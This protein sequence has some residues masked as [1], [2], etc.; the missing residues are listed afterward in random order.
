MTIREG[1]LA[2]VALI[3]SVDILR[4]KIEKTL[5]QFGIDDVQS[6]R[7][8]VFMLA[9]K[10]LL[11][12]DTELVILDVESRLYDAHQIIVKLKAH[13][14]S[15]GLPILAIGNGA[16]KGTIIKLLKSGCTS[17]V[18]APID[19]M[20][21]ASRILEIIR[22]KGKVMSE[23]IKTPAVSSNI[24]IKLEWSSDFEIGIESIDQE[25]RAIIENYCKLYN[26]MKSGKG[27]TFYAELLEFLT[28]YVDVH[29]KNEE[30]YQN[31][32]GYD[33]IEAHKA[34]HEFFREK[35]SAF[36]REGNQAVSNA[37]LIKLN[38]FVKDWLIRHIYLEDKKIADFVK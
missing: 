6:I 5:Q 28:D 15:Q 18:K 8:N 2:K 14:T 38:L 11:Q 20:T 27:H 17:Y 22:D 30:W 7:D 3:F 19:E 37:D 21:L 34:K 10:E 1:A 23:S 24:D 12:G 4:H 26:L 9:N 25:H 36:I 35:I 33:Q 13:K 32:I 16:D 31:E 29:F